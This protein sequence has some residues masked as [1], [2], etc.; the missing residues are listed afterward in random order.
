MLLLVVNIMDP[1]KIGKFISS[2]RKENNM[3]QSDLASILNVTNQAVSKWENGRGIPDIEMLKKLSEVFNI[4]IEEILSGEENKKVKRK[5]IFYFIILFLVVVLLVVLVIFLNTKKEDFHFSSL[6][7][8]NDSFSIKGVMAY[9][10]DKKSIYISEVNYDGKDEEKYKSM[11]CILYESNDS[12]EKIISKYG[13]IDDKKTNMFLLSELLKG[14]EFN[15]DSYECSCTKEFC[16][17]LFLRINVKNMD[18]KIITY[19]IPIQLDR[20]CEV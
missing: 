12:L 19:Q 14:V 11:E 9:S 17:N 18:N 15:I 16:N 10:K 5:N 3:S 7:T 2:K 13:D 1:I 6:A 8:D 4:N 20:S